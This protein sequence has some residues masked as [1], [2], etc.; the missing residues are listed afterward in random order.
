M[1]GVSVGTVDRVIHDRGNVSEEAEKKIKAILKQTNYSPNPIAQSLGSKKN[2][3]IIVL[4]P[5]PS[6]DEYWQLSNAG[7]NQARQEWESYN[8]DIDTFTFDLDKPESFA[9]SAQKVLKANPDAI[10]TA[11]IFYEE[12]LAFFED[13]QSSKIPYILVNTEINKQIQQF[14]PL[15]SIGQDHR[16]SG[17]VAAEL[18]HIALREPGKVAVM[19]IHENIE[20]SIHLKEKEEGFRN[21]FEELSSG[22]EVHTFSFLDESE[23]FEAQIGDCIKK[24]NL[25]GI[26]VPTSSGTFLT[27]QALKNHQQEHIQLIG[28]DLLQQNIHFLQSGI[29]NFLINQNPRHQAFQGLRYL[30]DHLLLNLDI[31]PADLLPLEII[32]R[33]NY[34]SFLEEEGEQL[35]K[36]V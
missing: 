32:T 15:C 11:P 30:V 2:Y 10:L 23:A 24:T 25:K 4:L 12:S 31:P 22:F 9:T 14:H 29:I 26:F 6:Q 8:I 16:Q 34:T 5:R 33:Q 27:A 1:A 3:R 28:Y 20:R 13:L 18:M 35:P 21:Y 17:K 36:T 19:H 7:I